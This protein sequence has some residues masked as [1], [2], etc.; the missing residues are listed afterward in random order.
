MSEDRIEKKTFTFTGRCGYPKLNPTNP[1]LQGLEPN[2]RKRWSLNVYLDPNAKSTKGH[3]AM[4]TDAAA[5]FEELHGYEPAKTP[6]LKKVTEWANKQRTRKNDPSLIGLLS[7][8]LGKNA[9]KQDGGLHP[10]ISLVDTDREPIPH[11][12]IYPGCYVRVV[13]V[14]DE[15]KRKNERGAIIAHGL[16]F[17][18]KLVQFVKDGER[19]GGDNTDY[20]KYL[21]DEYEVEGETYGGDVISDDDI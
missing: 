6:K 11:T 9:E 18:L 19:M 4:L 2:Q 7:I 17:N 10:P 3:Q 5:E 8:E 20:T 16:S 12:D 21:D 13:A 14:L 1:P 15:Y